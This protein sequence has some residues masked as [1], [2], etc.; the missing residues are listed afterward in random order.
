MRSP[1][2]TGPHDPSEAKLEV[3][4]KLLERLLDDSPQA[5]HNAA[6]CFLHLYSVL[7]CQDGYVSVF[8]DLLIPKP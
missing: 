6:V 5:A 3:M 8:P 4:N 7:L 1:L 2:D